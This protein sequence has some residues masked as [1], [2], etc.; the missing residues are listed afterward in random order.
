MTGFDAVKQAI[1]AK[2]GPLE[3]LVGT[4]VTIAIPT[5][6]RLILGSSADPAPFVTYF[7][8]VLLGAIFL[9]WKWAVVS[10]VAS[11][12]IV[13]IAFGPLIVEG[14]TA[15][16]LAVLF[17][18][19]CSC[20]LLIAT[21]DMLRRVTRHMA[22][23]TEERNL[24]LREMGHRVQNTLAV[25][26]SLVRMDRGSKDLE[27]FKSDLLGRVKALASAN[28]VLRDGAEEG[29]SVLHLVEQAIAPFAPGEAFDAQGTDHTIDA[30]AAQH[31]LLILHEL[32]TNAVKHGALRS[33][34]GRVELRWR[35][36]DRA[37]QLTWREHGGPRVERPSGPGLGTKLLRSQPAFKIETQFLPD[38]L[39]ARITQA[40][41]KAA[42][43]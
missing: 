4:L 42:T 29:C 30:Q 41:G 36:A 10:T 19:V 21:G 8:F 25:V 5:G 31:L 14:D 20:A 12:L 24:L 16:E 18:F 43:G 38:G 3:S 39:Y 32:C 22:R 15:R 1:L 13:E 9:G 34:A 23:V 17:Y 11:A 37:L 7:P 26:A 6:L 33:A 35:V 28:R 27:S 2:R 40:P